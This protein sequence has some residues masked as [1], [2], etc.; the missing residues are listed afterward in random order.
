MTTAA[1]RRVRR[2]GRALL[3]LLLFLGGAAA[4]LP[5][6]VAL[7]PGRRVLA[8]YA[9]SV[10]APGSIECS[11]IQASWFGP[12][13]VSDVTLRDAEGDAV[14]AAPSLTFSW[15]LWQ[16]LVKR[17][18]T[19]HLDLTGAKL[20]I[21]R[22]SDGTI[23]LQETLKPV[24]PEHPRV[25]ILI[26]LEKSHLRLRDPLLD[27]P[28][29]ADDLNV[30]LDMSRGYEPISWKISMALEELAGQSGRLELEGSQSRARVDRSGRH[31]TKVVLKGKNW[32]FAVANADM[33]I[34]CRGV[35]DGAIDVDLRSDLW[36]AKGET[37]LGHVELSAPGLAE[38][39]Q[40]DTVK[41]GWDLSGKESGWTVDRLSLQSSLVSLNAEGTVPA[42]SKQGAWLEADFNLAD[43]ARYLPTALRPRNGAD[44]ERGHARLRADLKAGADGMTQNCDVRGTLSDLI[45]FPGRR[46]LAATEAAAVRA[47][48]QPDGDVIFSLHASYDPHSD[49]LDL[50]EVGLTLPFFRVRG[51][52]VIGDLTGKSQ[53]D[54]K[55]TL[56]PDWRALTALLADRVEPKARIAGQPRPWHLAASIASLRSGDALNTI[57]GELGIQ[58]DEL[59]LFGMRLGQS[60][61]VARAENGKIRLDPIDATLNQGAL[62]LEPEV[63]RDQDGKRCLWLGESSY[64]KGAVINDEVSHRVLSYAAPVLDGATRVKGRISAILGEA[65]FPVTARSAAAARV[66]GDLI[67][68]DVRFLPGRLA[69]QLLIGFKREE[70]PLL[71]L[72]DSIAIRIEDGKVHQ[73][74][75][76]ISVADVASI[77]LDGSVDFDKNLDL[78]ASLA[79]SRSGPIA[80]VLPPLLQN[81]RVDVPIRGTLEHPEI[82]ASGFKDRLADM[83]MD[84]FGNSVEAGLNGLKRVLGG[85]SLKGLGDYFLPRPRPM[86]PRPGAE[87][88]DPKSREPRQ[89]P[90]VPPEPEPAPGGATE[91][92]TDGSGGK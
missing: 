7:P 33:G 86:S 81:A 48:Q 15:G 59:D 68:D 16:I 25:Q 46:A 30:D 40:L 5:W 85:K 83:G 61:L 36:L 54:L 87:N 27:E 31:D 34:K 69:E 58:I 53:L 18:K 37:E 22:R 41:A 6:L 44:A 47:P 3:V 49:R 92:D 73:K 13:V 45:A 55:G 35:L 8:A 65:V 29:L 62:H 56:D 72:R 51:A 12:A 23:D 10:L 19:A 90:T 66:A 39:I 74:G 52:G 70:K 11:T 14:L 42:V 60:A 1:Q 78:V 64:L 26:H 80:G 63:R 50:T 20:D 43:L 84:I 4:G 75:L 17:P 57:S 76:I 38:T 91:K 9:N 67:L 21:E 2:W 79:M 82:D 24:T 32:P 77:A 88:V 28:L 89:P 71:I